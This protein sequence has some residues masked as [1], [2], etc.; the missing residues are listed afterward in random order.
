[1]IVIIKICRHV[2]PS[3]KNWAKPHAV[4]LMPAS[5][6]DVDEVTSWFDD[7]RQSFTLTLS[8]DSFEHETQ[9]STGATTGDW[10]VRL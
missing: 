6:L 8:D 10:F 1:V 7:N 9:A 3:Y 5:S 2:K 4:V